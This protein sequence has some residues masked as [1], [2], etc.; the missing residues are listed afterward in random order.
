M[1]VA[2]LLLA[3]S[4]AAA[5]FASTLAFPSPAAVALTWLVAGLFIAALLRVHAV[6]NAPRRDR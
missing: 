5:W 4:F 6:V 1:R 2:M 3:L